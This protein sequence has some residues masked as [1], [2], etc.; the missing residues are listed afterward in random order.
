MKIST[1]HFHLYVESK[2]NKMNGYIKQ[3]QTHRHREPNCYQWGEELGEGQDRGRDLR[4]MN[5]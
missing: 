5:Y 4:G 1:V 3:K 2:K